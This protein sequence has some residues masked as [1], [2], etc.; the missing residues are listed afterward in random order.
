MRAHQIRINHCGICDKLNSGHSRNHIPCAA[1]LDGTGTVGG[2][3]LE[4]SIDGA[5]VNANQ[6]ETPV[7]TTTERNGLDATPDVDTLG[8]PRWDTL[9]F[10]ETSSPSPLSP[11]SVHTKP[12]AELSR[13]VPVLKVRLVPSGTNSGLNLC[14]G[15]GGGNTPHSTTSS[16][17]NSEPAELQSSSICT[18][19]VRFGLSCCNQS[20]QRCW[21]CAFGLFY[22]SEGGK[23]GKHCGSC[24]GH[25]HSV[26]I[27]LSVQR[28]WVAGLNHSDT[29]L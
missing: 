5:S 18:T 11:S 8:G 10:S 9:P 23:T 26:E 2:R 4:I 29:L 16:Q 17:Q 13:R 27:Q 28:S 14:G 19:L 24:G 15:E 6:P 7:R 1:A 25:S 12:D 3:R 21:N 22:S 20:P